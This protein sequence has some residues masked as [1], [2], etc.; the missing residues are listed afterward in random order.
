MGLS[1][2]FIFAQVE[3]PCVQ[4]LHRSSYASKER[5]TIQVAVEETPSTDREQNQNNQ[6][7][8]S[9]PATKTKTNQKPAARNQLQPGAQLK[10]PCQPKCE[11][12]T[13][14]MNSAFALS[15][16]SPQ[17]GADQHSSDR[18]NPLGGDLYCRSVKHLERGHIGRVPC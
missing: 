15:A 8:Q 2:P 6:T 18:S 14:A 9:N 3:T 12:V 13:G 1:G 16:S 11:K 5:V 10:R 17:R 4:R 7:P